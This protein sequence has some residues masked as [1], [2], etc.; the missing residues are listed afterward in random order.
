[1][2][3][4]VPPIHQETKQEAAQRNKKVAAATI[5]GSMLEWYDFYLYA[6][7]ASIVFFSTIPTLPLLLFCRFPR[8]PSVLWLGPLV[9]CFSDILGIGLAAKKC[10]SSLFV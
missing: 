5:F 9:V 1:M 10:C 4:S 6:T 8:S 2:Q 7:M 3:H